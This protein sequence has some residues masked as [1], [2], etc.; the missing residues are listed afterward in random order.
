MKHDTP[1][2]PNPAPAGRPNARSVDA[3]AHLIASLRRIKQKQAKLSKERKEHEAVL[4]AALVAAG[5]ELGTVNDVPVVS[6][7]SSMRIAVDQS[8]LKERFPDVARECADIS[9]VWTFRLLDT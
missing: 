9:E 6:F 7:S 3:F 8:V 1:I 4:K 2:R 5:A